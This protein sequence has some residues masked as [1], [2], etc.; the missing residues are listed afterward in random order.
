MA[1]V[2]KMPTAPK[3]T[4]T[5][6]YAG[7]GDM[8]DGPNQTIG[9][10]G[11]AHKT[12]R[13]LDTLIG[14]HPDYTPP[15]GVL[16]KGLHIAPLGDDAYQSGSHAQF[17]SEY[18]PW[19]GAG[20]GSPANPATYYMNKK[21]WTWPTPGNHDGY[22]DTGTAS[23][24][25]NEPEYSAYDDEFGSRATGMDT[26]P[27]VYQG[28]YPGR[29]LPGGRYYAVDMVAPDGKAYWLHVVLNSDKGESGP[30]NT[31]T[32]QLTWLDAMIANAGNT[33]ATLTTPRADGSRN[34]R[35][36]GFKQHIVVSQH[37]PLMA[38]SRKWK[39]GVA[40][41]SN[42]E[43][44]QAAFWM[45]LQAYKG[46]CKIVNAGHY[47]YYAR[48]EPVQWASAGAGI[49]SAASSISS[50]LTDGIVLILNGIGGTNSMNF[51]GDP[52]IAIHMNHLIKSID[53]AYVITHLMLRD[54]GYR[55]EG[56]AIDDPTVGNVFDDP[57]ATTAN[58][59]FS[60]AGSTP[61]SLVLNA[62]PA[63]GAA[64]VTVTATMTAT[65]GTAPI[66]AGAYGVDWGDGQVSVG[67]GAA[68]THTYASAGTYSIVGT[69][70]DN[71]GLVGSAT[72]SVLVTAS[73]AVPTAAVNLNPG[74]NGPAPFTVVADAG[75]SQ[76]VT[77]GGGG[78]TTPQ[79]GIIILENT[80][81][82]AANADGYLG[83]SV[84]GRV[85]FDYEAM[86][87]LY[88]V[89]HPSLPNYAALTSGSMLGGSPSNGVLADGADGM[90]WTP[91]LANNIFK[92]LDGA[93]R[94][95]KIYAQDYNPGGTPN[96]TTGHYA[97]RHDPGQFY[98]FT[99]T[100]ANHQ[101]FS[102]SGGFI[103]DIANSSLPDF[104]FAAPNIFNMG[105]APSNLANAS[106]WLH[107]DNPQANTL[108]RFLG[109][110]DLLSHMRPNGIVIV[111]FDEA[112]TDNTN[113]GGRIY[114]VV[115]GA[116]TAGL[117]DYTTQLSH[118]G[119]LAGIQQA[120]GQ[121]RFTD[122]GIAAYD[123]DPNYLTAQVAPLSIGS[124]SVH[125]IVGYRFDW[126]DASAVQGGATNTVSS[127]QH[128][129]AAAGAYTLT[130]TVWDSG[131]TSAS[132]TRTITVTNPSATP[133]RASLSVDPPRGRLAGVSGGGGADR[134]Y[135]MAVAA[136][137][138]GSSYA[139][140][141]TFLFD[142]ADGTTTGPQAGPTASHTY[143]YN[144]LN[145]Y[146]DG[147]GR[148]DVKVTVT[149]ANGTDTAVSR[150]WVQRDHTLPGLAN[151]GI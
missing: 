63:S 66:G 53:G 24:P 120:F 104:F 29:G 94:S 73:T 20:S 56:V 118:Y 116:A 119:I 89:F 69:V 143:R 12:G 5:V 130:V 75:A 84:A 87:Q 150:V 78:S 32:R 61:P 65:P 46:G 80:D 59:T 50:N 133:P 18:D 129:Y 14:L 106:A 122:S 83:N 82:A 114:G 100:H 124:G 42:G 125:T 51:V 25:L 60:P 108:G 117:A 93:G 131:G 88:A 45:K 147:W 13:V 34:S 146:K 110:P 33:G 142:W 22:N 92:Q 2:V 1:V 144:H 141:A 39:N 105:H 37:Y 127:R 55:C 145:A 70:T 79:I 71:N 49:G 123:L 26:H 35:H 151:G 8:G 21:P 134:E 11:L 15:D 43:Q 7:A 10:P 91:V 137:A 62:T 107:G 6:Y 27:D 4:R 85:S 3:P 102:G 58:F 101:D 48:T 136:D 23:N 40:G 81:Y 95:W 38:F 112:D 47:H 96:S 97:S 148:K 132:T 86:T 68:P 138:S 72:D 41:G 103:A 28:F 149:D 126:G 135:T 99:R 90:G 76:P 9:G 36:V 98:S 16:R 115:V 128:V 113:G 31:Y 121:P 77:G 140:G 74:L 111:M 19:W 57:N 17:A 64:P 44:D 52:D 139:A 109:L 54:D 30:V 67:V